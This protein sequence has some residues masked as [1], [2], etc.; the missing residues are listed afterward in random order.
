MKT[1]AVNASRDIY[2]QNGLLVIA[3][4]AEGLAQKCTQIMSTLRGELQYD[5][6]RGIPYQ[7]V[8]WSGSPN[9]LA[10]EAAAREA[11]MSLAGVT[12]V[13]S[14]AVQL[15]DNVLN[16]QANINTIFGRQVISG[17]L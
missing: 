1:L 12:G 8:L 16:Y 3:E 14:F 6:L 4:N 11:I 7:Q 9:V 15:S 13:D 10:F 17:D 2:T 5:Q